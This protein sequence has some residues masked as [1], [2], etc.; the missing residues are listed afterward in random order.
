MSTRSWKNSLRKFAR[1]IQDHITACAKIEEALTNIDLALAAR[2]PDW[3]LTHAEHRASKQV[4]EALANFDLALAEAKHAH[5]KLMD[6]KSPKRLLIDWLV[7]TDRADDMLLALQK[8]F[9][10]WV[11]KYGVRRARRMF[12]WHAFWSVIGCWINCLMKHLR[13]LKFLASGRG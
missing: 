9:E 6:A 13:L 10:R 8:G 1:K 3:G 11:P 5:R 12:L 2:R 4:A 7:P